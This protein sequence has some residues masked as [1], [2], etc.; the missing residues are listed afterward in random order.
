VMDTYVCDGSKG[1]T[2]E[3]TERV[4]YHQSQ[5]MNKRYWEDDG[6]FKDT[7]ASEVLFLSEFGSSV[8]RYIRRLMD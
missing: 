2:R 4:G 8:I 7:C 1:Y 6:L 3:V 5:A